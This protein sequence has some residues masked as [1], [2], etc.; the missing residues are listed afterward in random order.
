MAQHNVVREL[1]FNTL[2]DLIG[3]D[4]MIPSVRDLGQTGVTASKLRLLYVL[5]ERTVYRV[6]VIYKTTVADQVLQD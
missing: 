5:H 2:L 1:H 6:I 4:L 3:S